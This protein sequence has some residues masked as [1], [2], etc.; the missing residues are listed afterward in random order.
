MI[1]IGFIPS[2][3]S[4]QIHAALQAVGAVSVP[5]LPAALAFYEL[6]ATYSPSACALYTN[7]HVYGMDAASGAAV[8]VLGPRPGESVLD[9]CCC[10]G[11]KLCLMAD[12]MQGRGR[13]TG[14][15]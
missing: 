6:P 13:L 4:V 7:A 5:W 1:S 14:E 12:L 8:M 3:P 10:P 9:L 2:S 15:L 11:A